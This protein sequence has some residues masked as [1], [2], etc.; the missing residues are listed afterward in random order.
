MASPDMNGIDRCAA[1][2]PR[3]YPKTVMQDNRLWYL[4]R[5]G[6]AARPSIRGRMRG[7]TNLTSRHVRWPAWRVSAVGETGLLVGF[8]LN[9]CYGIDSLV[10]D[11][12]ACT[13]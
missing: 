2:L 11:I 4:I 6:H 7:E 9:G 1:A 3:T 13:L 12:Y 5:R 8:V 10:W